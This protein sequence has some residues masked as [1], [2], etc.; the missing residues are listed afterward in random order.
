MP[1]QA[2]A[3][4]LSSG[5]NTMKYI[6]SLRKNNISDRHK[7]ASGNTHARAESARVGTRMYLELQALQ[8]LETIT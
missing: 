3:S 5:K 4:Y 8:Q 6:K 7:F 1:S 2:I